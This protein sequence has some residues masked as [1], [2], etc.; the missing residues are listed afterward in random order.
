MTLFLNMSPQ[1]KVDQMIAH[2]D[3]SCK[4]FTEL[5]SKD[6]PHYKALLV[7]AEMS[8]T[9]VFEILEIQ[10]AKIPEWKTIEEREQEKD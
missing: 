3:L 9:K 4:A 2:H 5:E 8:M 1:Q 10:G 6:R 7:K